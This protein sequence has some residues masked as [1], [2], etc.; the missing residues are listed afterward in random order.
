MGVYIAISASR[1]RRAAFPVLPLILT[2]CSTMNSS[3]RG[4][5]TPVSLLFVSL[6]FGQFGDIFFYS[7]RI[8]DGMNH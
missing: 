4:L 5:L 7:N 1:L 6:F 8:Y 2:P 3:V